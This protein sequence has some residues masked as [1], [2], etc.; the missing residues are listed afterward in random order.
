MNLQKIVVVTYVTSGIIPD[1]Q[2][3][4]RV[5]STCEDFPLTIQRYNTRMER[6][7]FL[8]SLQNRLD[9]DKLV[10]KETLPTTFNVEGTQMI[11][12]YM[13]ADVLVYRY[14]HQN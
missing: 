4:I 13:P 3:E 5:V 10:L 11:R 12:I 2:G 8:Q 14:P 1:Q 9:A 6:V 7:V